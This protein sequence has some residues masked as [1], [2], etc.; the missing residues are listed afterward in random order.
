M[1]LVDGAWAAAT[2]AADPDRRADA[3]AAVIAA[4]LGW[5]YLPL[6]LAVELYQALPAASLWVVPGQGH[7]PICY[8]GLAAE[9]FPR[10]VQEFL[11]GEGPE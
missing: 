4:S 1:T 8:H 10:L 3:A 2:A 5:I 7:L 9:V 11:L 6:A